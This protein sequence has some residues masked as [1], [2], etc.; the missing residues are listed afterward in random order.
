[1]PRWS[2]THTLLIAI[3]AIGLAGCPPVVQDLAPVAN[4]SATPRSGNTGLVVTFSDLSTSGAGGAITAWQWNFGD[5]ARSN[6]PNPTHTYFSAGAFDV[7][8]TVTSSGGSHTRTRAGYIQVSSPAGSASLD[9]GG[10]TASANGVS[11]TAAAGAL[12]GAVNFGITRVTGEIALNFFETINRVGDTFRITH[13][14]DTNMTASSQEAPVQPLALSIPYA[15]DV[16]P[17]GSRIPAKVH[18][19]AELEDGR[20]IPILGKI[21]SGAVVAEVTGL[22]ASA[23]YTVV[24]R[25][26]A[27]IASLDTSGG[28]KAATGTSWNNAWQVSLSP[29]LLKQLTALRLGTVQRA[30]SFGN[31][32]FTEAQLQDTLDA[33]QASLAAYQGD[34]ESVR[35]RAPRLVSVDGAYMIALYNS[36][37]TYPT[38]IGSI[39]NVF[40]AGSPYGAVVLDPAQLLAI[41]TWNADRFASN[42][43]NVDIAYKLSAEQAVVEV[44]TRAV[45]DGYDYP[46]VTANSPADG[47]AVSFSAGIREGLALYL[48]QVYGGMGASRA[49]LEG[50]YALLSTPVL[51]PLDTS[52]ANYAASGQEFLRYV[53]NRYAPESGLEYIV[54]GTGP[55]KGFVEGIRLALE[56]VNN[57]SFDAASLATATAIDNAF[58]AYLDVS[59]GEAYREFAL[60]LAFEQGDAA[61]LRPSDA[62]RLPLVLDESRFAP[63]TVISGTID[64]PDGGLDFQTPLANIP[65]LSTRVV[66]VSADPS[67]A[68]L[69]FGF[70]RGDWTVDARNQSVYA[71]VYREGLQGTP[72][73]ANASELVFTDFE[74]DLGKTTADFVVLVVNTSVTTFNSVEVSAISSST[75]AAN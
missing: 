22:P 3:T 38:T 71:V 61:A 43:D 65:P 72:L 2:F 11:I 60:D 5:G 57:V 6:S 53:N 48:G 44:V 31:R 36:V 28:A 64:G 59:V 23:L 73:P 67:A 12:D 14:G 18:I 27:Y 52:T 13:D 46:V 15:E 7:S 37:D 70:N 51:A 35:G 42:A 47:A 16:V 58:F 56:G 26:D 40:Y 19:L 8:L 49:Q 66:K 17:T 45:V 50:D 75:V 9:G 29:T 74:A 10:G 4:F 54:A 24:Y 33:L 30:S 41:S 69:T 25:P 21:R 32:S 20:V 63:G 62:D 39:D 1:M 55:V 34:F 68:S